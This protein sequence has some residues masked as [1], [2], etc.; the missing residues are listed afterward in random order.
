MAGAGTAGVGT[1]AAGALSA[2]RTSVGLALTG[3]T[4]RV[5]P[6][7]SSTT[8]TARAPTAARQP[9][10]T[11]AST[12]PLLLKTPPLSAWPAPVGCRSQA[13]TPAARGPARAAAARRDAA[14]RNKHSCESRDRAVSVLRRFRSCKAT[15]RGPMASG[16]NARP[17]AP[18]RPLTASPRQRRPHGRTRQALAQRRTL[19]PSRA[20][21]SPQPT[22][23]S[24]QA[25]PVPVRSSASIKAVSSLA[26]YRRIRAVCIL[27]VFTR[28]TWL[29]GAENLAAVRLSAYNDLSKHMRMIFD[30]ACYGAKHQQPHRS[31]LAQGEFQDHRTERGRLRSPA[32]GPRGPRGKPAPASIPSGP[33]RP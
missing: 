20:A 6:L 30:R 12:A 1:A 8:R 11:S 5:A 9:T 13:D 16:L 14:C 17:H 4:G 27:N 19:L 23:L 10:I 21:D 33:G 28:R 24:C 29:H 32:R 2:D 7:R 22:I 18:C 31:H 3:A 15:R 26:R 25:G